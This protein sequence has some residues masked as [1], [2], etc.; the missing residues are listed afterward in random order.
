MSRGKSS[1][2]RR[3][4]CGIDIEGFVARVRP[5]QFYG[6]RRLGQCSAAADPLDDFPFLVNV[7][8]V[9]ALGT[10]EAEMKGCQIPAGRLLVLSRWSLP[11]F[12]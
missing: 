12:M 2:C 7:L 11:L 1:I 3:A 8:R 6:D 5:C 4:R 9:H 10:V